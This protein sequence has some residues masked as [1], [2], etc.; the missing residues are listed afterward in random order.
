[1]NPEKMRGEYGKLAYLL[2][3]AVSPTIMRHLHVKV[4]GEL[5]TVYTLLEA[6]GVC[7]CVCVCLCMC[8]CVFV[9]VCVCVQQILPDPSHSLTFT[10][11]H[12]HTHTPKKKTGGLAVLDDV[13]LIY[14]A[15]QEIL[16]DPSKSRAQIQGEIKKKERAIEALV[17][18][19]RSM[20]LR[21]EEIRL[22]L[23]SICDNH[24][25]LNSNR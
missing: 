16:P 1:M 2:Q 20:S 23:Y 3:D 8:L 21:E 6:K 14:T 15:T 11:T 9:S 24:S 19:Y 17:A 13:P 18:K 22:C 10:H 7:V 25:F 4:V 5:Q 12:T